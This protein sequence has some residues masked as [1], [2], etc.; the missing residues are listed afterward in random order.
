MLPLSC[1]LTPCSLTHSFKFNLLD[2]LNVTSPLGIPWNPI[3]HK[4]HD[5]QSSF[6]YISFDWDISL[7]MVSLSSE[8]YCCLLSIVSSI[9]SYPCTQVN[10]KLV[11]L[12][13]GSLQHVTLVYPHGHHHLPSL[14]S[15]QSKFPNYFFLHHML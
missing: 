13:H 3:S 10:H 12:I 15:F 4:G 14:S 11:A 5:F 9:L 7:C 6:S 2:I 8:E 1:S